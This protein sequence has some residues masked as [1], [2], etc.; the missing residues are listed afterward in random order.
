[1]AIALGVAAIV[2]FAPPAID[3][4]GA[5]CWKLAPWIIVL[6]VA[7]VTAVTALFC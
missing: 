3:T 1:M 4:V 5:M 2:L 6:G 7:T